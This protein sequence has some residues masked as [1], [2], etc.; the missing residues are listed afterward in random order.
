MRLSWVQAF[1]KA[2]SVFKQ[3]AAIHVGSTLLCQQGVNNSRDTLEIAS[4][5]Q[6]SCRWL[7]VCLLGQ[8]PVK[9]IS[10]GVNSLLF[11]ATLLSPS[12]SRANTHREGASRPPKGWTCLQWRLGWL[13]FCLLLKMSR[14]KVTHDRT[15]GESWRTLANCYSKKQM[16][17]VSI[18]R[19]WKKE[20][21]FGASRTAQLNK[22]NKGICVVL[23]HHMSGEPSL[24]SWYGLWLESIKGPIFGKICFTNVFWQKYVSL[25]RKK[26][27]KYILRF[28]S[29]LI[30][31]ESVY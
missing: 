14:E 28:F 1:P 20:R 13:S 2:G 4:V 26:W 5:A 27:E 15:C 17:S 8:L 29:L 22:G 31:S 18:Q 6:C 7:T 30:F 23:R 25:G 16:G 3:T 10:L 9:L 12:I 11:K 21:D 24:K 19:S